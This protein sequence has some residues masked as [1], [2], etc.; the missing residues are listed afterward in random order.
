MNRVRPW[1]PILLALSASS[2]FWGG[3]NTGYAS[4]RSVIMSRCL[5]LSGVPPAFDSFAAYARS[6]QAVID[7]EV[8]V[9]VRQAFWDVRPGVAHDTV[10]FRS[11][12]PARRSTTPSSGRPLPGP[13]TDSV[14]STRSARAARLPTYAPELL[15]AARWR[16]GRFGLADRLL[17]PLTGSLLPAATVVDRFI[18]HVADALEQSRDRA[19]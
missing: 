12:T 2:P 16:A 14:P 11:P 5:P 6:V 18:G 13:R 9:D 3:D 8:A 17:D 10:E 1:L 19:R 15:R 7:A 4:Y